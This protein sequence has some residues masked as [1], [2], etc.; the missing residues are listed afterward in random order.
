[1]RESRRGPSW[2]TCIQIYQIPLVK[3]LTLPPP[4]RPLAITF[5]P[6]TPPPPPPHPF[7]EEEILNPRLTHESLCE[8]YNFS[9][10]I[11]VHFKP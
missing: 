5:I 4:S 8:H 3:L 2:S 10:P 6:L 7:H 1:M 11:I 9:T